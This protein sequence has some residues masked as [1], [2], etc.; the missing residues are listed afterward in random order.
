MRKNSLTVTVIAVAL[1]SLTAWG[2]D[3]P[4]RPAELQVLDRFVGTWDLDVTSTPTDGEIITGK[5]SE[6]RSWT[7]GGKFVQFENPQTENPDE[8]EFQM[9]VTYDSTTKTYPGVMMSGPSRAIV[10]GT[11]DQAKQTMTFSGTFSDDSGVKF[12]YAI[13]FLNNDHCESSGVIRGSN[14][15]VLVKHVQKQVRR[16]K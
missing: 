4:I 5:T 9:L 6:T 16:T 10:T 1:C 7:M 13:R 15:T 12:E 3:A 14:G 2:Q 11:W 8:H